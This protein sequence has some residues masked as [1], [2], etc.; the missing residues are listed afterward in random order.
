MLD[1]FYTQKQGSLL[2]SI[3]CTLFTG[4]FHFLKLPFSQLC[5]SQCVYGTA[6]MYVELVVCVLV[7]LTWRIFGLY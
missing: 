7:R 1:C 5:L 4:L 2:I 6:T 3:N